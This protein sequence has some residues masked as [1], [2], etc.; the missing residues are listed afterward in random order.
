MST[1]ARRRP[2]AS[3]HAP[4][5]WTHFLSLAGFIASLGIIIGALGASF[6]AQVYFRHVAFVDEET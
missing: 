6:E 5:G 1:A 2:A 4:L 3:L